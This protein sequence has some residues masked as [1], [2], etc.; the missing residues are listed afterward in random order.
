MITLNRAISQ[1]LAIKI[2]NFLA[3]RFF[4][5]GDGVARRLVW[6]DSCAILPRCQYS[7][8]TTV[9][10]GDL[11][12]VIHILGNLPAVVLFLKNL[13]G[14]NGLAL[15]DI[16]SSQVALQ[17]K[18]SKSRSFLISGRE[19]TLKNLSCHLGLLRAH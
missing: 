19:G 16:A 10:I 8:C 15:A 13:K 5:Y 7:H 3:T 17:K 9:S 14:S 6:Y 18:S 1:R 2:M 4:F 11:L 12:K